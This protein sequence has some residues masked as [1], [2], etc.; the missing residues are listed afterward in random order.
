MNN[1][2]LRAQAKSV[3]LCMTL[4]QSQSAVRAMSRN[5]RHHTR[6]NATPSLSNPAPLSMNKSVRRLQSN[7]VRQSQKKFAA[8]LRVKA[9]GRSLKKFATKSWLKSVTLSM[10]SGVRVL[11]MS[12]VKLFRKKIARTLRRRCVKMSKPFATLFSLKNVTQ[13]MKMN[14]KLFTRRDAPLNMNLNAQQS[15]WR[16]ANRAMVAM[17]CLPLTVKENLSEP[18]MIARQSP[19]TIV[20]TLPNQ[21]VVKSRMNSVGRFLIVN[22]EGF[23]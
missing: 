11:R 7:N 9:V 1:N 23:R 2:A 12:N 21:T 15:M 16:P 8:R 20:A 5:V 18:E 3:A 4:S 22:V 13:S 14:V 6:R 10:T 19:S 17:C